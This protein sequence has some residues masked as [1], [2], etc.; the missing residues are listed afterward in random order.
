MQ[1]PTSN[2]V[3]QS[4]KLFAEE[5]DDTTDDPFRV[6][7]VARYGGK[8]PVYTVTIPCAEKEPIRS[9][10][11]QVLNRSFSL[12]GSS[13]ALNAS[14]AQIILQYRQKPVAAPGTRSL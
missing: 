4:L 2:E 6:D 13:F 1:Y 3:E 10:L 8:P 9:K 12:G 11:G 7:M 5:L 14:E